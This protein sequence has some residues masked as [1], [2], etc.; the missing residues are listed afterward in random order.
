MI[1]IRKTAS[2]ALLVSALAL[3]ACTYDDYGRGG[4][5]VGYGSGYYHDPYPYGY[6]PYGWYDNYYYPGNGYWLYDRRG[7]R[8]RWSDKQRRYWEDRRHR[9]GKWD[10]PKSRPWKPE[11]RNERRWSGSD[12]RRD[13]DR[14]WRGRS[15]SNAP[16]ARPAPTARE[17]GTNEMFRQR[18]NRANK[19]D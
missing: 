18:Y 14:G 1:G 5:S 15:D 19:R 10:G 8:H 11:M 17:N 13:G 16:R 7:D 9:S 3:G 12:Q 4:V 6:A 2:A